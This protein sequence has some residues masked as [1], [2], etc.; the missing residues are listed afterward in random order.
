MEPY[1]SLPTWVILLGAGAS[2]EA[3]YPLYRDITNEARLKERF[4]Q[5]LVHEKNRAEAALEAILEEEN[6][7]RFVSINYDAARIEFARLFSRCAEISKRQMHFEQYLKEMAETDSELLQAAL[8]Y[9]YDLLAVPEYHLKP[10]SLDYLHVFLSIPFLATPVRVV[11]IS[12]NHDLLVERC[13]KWEFHYG[14]MEEM[15]FRSCGISQD[16]K[17]P[18]TLGQKHPTTTPF[19]INLIKLH[20]SINWIKCKSCGHVVYSNVPLRLKDGFG[21]IFRRVHPCPRCGQNDPW[22]T[23]LVPPTTEKDIAQV[24]GFWEASKKTMSEADFITIAGYSFPEYDRD[25]WSLLD[26]I[27]KARFVEIIEPFPSAATTTIN[28]EL[29]LKGIRCFIHQTTVKLYARQGFEVLYGFD[30]FPDDCE[31]YQGPPELNPIWF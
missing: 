16:T 3:G 12:F 30:P 13:M 20:G 6:L 25:A 26:A 15:T 18:L 14:G 21:W 4:S 23:T 27:T 28:D 22:E 2:V 29:T 11:V 9:Y 7:S 1:D 17:E 31:E 24:A 5:F 10:Q 8:D 19:L